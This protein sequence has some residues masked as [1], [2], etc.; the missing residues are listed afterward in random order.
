MKQ[1]STTKQCGSLFLVAVFSCSFLFILFIIQ[2]ISL[3]I[4]E[5]IYIFFLAK[6]RKKKEYFDDDDDDFFS[7]SSA[8]VV[9]L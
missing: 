3:R 1:F 4:I 2:S 6:K 7:C 5:V 9:C 8:M